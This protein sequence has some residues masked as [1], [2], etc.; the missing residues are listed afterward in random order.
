MN[1][2][3]NGNYLEVIFKIHIR[4]TTQCYCSK[5][6]MNRYIKHKNKTSVNEFK[7]RWELPGGQIYS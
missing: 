3:T 4:E 2:N 1:S 7:C 6:K 5:E